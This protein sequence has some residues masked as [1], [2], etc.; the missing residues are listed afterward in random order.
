MMLLGGSGTK[1]SAFSSG[2]K[3]KIYSGPKRTF[4][5]V[6]NR[7]KKN[8][9]VLID[10]KQDFETQSPKGYLDTGNEKG[11]FGNYV[12]DSI[13][14]GSPPPVAPT[15]ANPVEDTSLTSLTGAT[16]VNNA[17]ANSI[18]LDNDILMSGGIGATKRGLELDDTAWDEL[19]I[20]T[21]K[22]LP[23]VVPQWTTNSL[24]K[25]KALPPR[26]SRTTAKARIK[27]TGKGWFMRLVHQVKPGH[28]E[29]AYIHM[30]ENVEETRTA[31]A[32]NSIDLKPHTAG[33]IQ[34]EVADPALNSIEGPLFC[35][36]LPGSS[37]YPQELDTTPAPS[38]SRVLAPANRSGD[39]TSSSQTGTFQPEH[40]TLPNSSTLLQKSL[41]QGALQSTNIRVKTYSPERRKTSHPESSTGH[42]RG[43]IE[44][45]S[46]Q[47]PVRYSCTCS[48]P[49]TWSDT[50]R[51][52]Y[53]PRSEGVERTDPTENSVSEE[54]PAVAIQPLSHWSSDSESENGTPEASGEAFRNT[55][56]EPCS[57]VSPATTRSSRGS[58]QNMETASSLM[59]HRRAFSFCNSESSSILGTTPEQQEMITKSPARGR[60]KHP[61][62]KIQ[63]STAKGKE[64]A[65]PTD[66]GFQIPEVQTPV[67]PCS[68]SQPDQTPKAWSDFDG[69]GEEDPIRLIKSYFRWRDDHAV[70]VHDEHSNGSAHTEPDFRESIYGS[71]PELAAA[72]SD[73]TYEHNLPSNS[74]VLSLLNKSMSAEGFRE[75]TGST[76]SQVE[77]CQLTDLETR[78]TVI[79]PPGDITTHPRAR[80][81][82]IRSQLTIFASLMARSILDR[83]VQCLKLIVETQLMTPAI[84]REHVRI[85]WTCVSLQI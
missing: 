28:A 40:E 47:L 85:R 7:D 79:T 44:P 19:E 81:R 33:D 15:S 66:I 38:T 80:E 58:M 12:V 60:S 4:S 36:E 75:A 52:H 32:L 59:Q 56:V 43:D 49:M 14:Y 74:P 82:L 22:F 45:V 2:G 18:T 77:A 21:D 20:N 35:Q 11:P 27:R 1:N 8:S 83:V 64:R 70:M 41:N 73:T 5:I 23:A 63:K 6:R 30:R 51:I 68:V 71:L 9:I 72:S 37:L 10:K 17:P 26:P 65:K 78:S 48:R 54:E 24:N 31:T 16:L 50:C 25:D 57:R 39:N 13:T 67:I 53:V 76:E 34:E 55:S 62:S 29:V 3:S 84:P 46:H 69:G 61:R 42:V